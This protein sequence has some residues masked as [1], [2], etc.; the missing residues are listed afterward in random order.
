MPKT[1]EKRFSFSELK[2]EKVKFFT[3]SSIKIFC[4]SVF[5]V[6]GLASSLTFR[7]FLTLDP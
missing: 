2:I 4:M 6:G 1:V 5:N 3:H 7:R